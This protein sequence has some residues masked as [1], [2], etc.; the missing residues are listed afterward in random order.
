[1]PTAVQAKPAQNILRHGQ[2][3]GL[4]RAPLIAQELS[5][6]DARFY[7]I[8]HLG[9][10]LKRNGIPKKSQ[11]WRMC[12][13]AARY[14]DEL[15]YTPDGRKRKKP[16][17]SLIPESKLWAAETGY[18]TTVQFLDE[19]KNMAE[20]GFLE[21]ESKGT[22]GRGRAYRYYPGKMFPRTVTDRNL[23][24]VGR[25]IHEE[26]IKSALAERATV[27]VKQKAAPKPAPAAAPLEVATFEDLGR[28]THVMIFD[29]IYSAF[30]TEQSDETTAALT[31]WLQHS[32]KIKK[33]NAGDPDVTDKLQCV[34]D[35][36][37]ELL[38]ESGLDN[39][40]LRAELHYTVAK[41]YKKQANLQLVKSFQENSNDNNS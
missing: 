1:M 5:R 23:V 27:P 17:E 11:I 30:E 4:Q 8:G 10:Y 22:G 16:L 21:R 19:F 2:R 40:E 41:L 15:H 7:V 3:P 34:I 26:L 33:L 35:R 29:Q 12:H 24:D 36:S 39:P 32:I 28:E 20:I 37:E 25:N 9:L 6:E 38:M 31:L 14:F 13:W 18:K